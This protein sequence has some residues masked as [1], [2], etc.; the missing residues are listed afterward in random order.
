M[1]DIRSLRVIFLSHIHPYYTRT[2]C[3]I[4]RGVSADTGGSGEP[5]TTVRA[6]AV[7]RKAA[8]PVKREVKPKETPKYVAKEV[9]P[10]DEA[11]MP[12][13]PQVPIS[14]F[15]RKPGS[16]MVT[17]FLDKAYGASHLSPAKVRPTQSTPIRS[18]A[19]TPI[20]S[21]FQKKAKLFG[22]PH[23]ATG[24]AQAGLPSL[25][26][27]CVEASGKYYTCV[28]I[29]FIDAMWEYLASNHMFRTHTH[30]YRYSRV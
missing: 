1:S 12:K 19:S 14:Q 27:V 20:K 5:Q 21:P 22:S 8:A 15:M 7:A 4:S 24:S 28:Y 10:K 3:L 9:E 13:Q 25:F 11:S 26:C 23:A 18:A 29:Y 2:D 30:L 17:D 6:K 16:G